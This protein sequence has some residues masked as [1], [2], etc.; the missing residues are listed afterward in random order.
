[1][2]RRF[3]LTQGETIRTELWFIFIVKLAASVHDDGVLMNDGWALYDLPRIRPKTPRM[4]CGIKAPKSASTEAIA[5]ATVW[6][7]IDDE[8]A[9]I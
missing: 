9:K 4:L 8:S 2:Q 1:M 6:C 7:E 5:A 3:L